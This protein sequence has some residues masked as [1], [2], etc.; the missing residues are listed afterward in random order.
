M[1]FSV[2]M[3][4]SRAVGRVVEH[5]SGAERIVPPDAVPQTVSSLAARAQRHDRG[6]PDSINIR[7]DAI[8]E[9][10]CLRLPALPAR[11]LDCADA[12]AGRRI[13]IDLL[14][15]AGVRNAGA[16]LSLLPAASRL[17]GAMLVDA[18]SL[19]RLEPDR[20]RGIRATCM[21]VSG[22]SPSPVKDHYREAL[23]L[24][25]KVA[26]APHIVAEICISD[27]PGYVIGYVASRKTGY[28]RIARMKESGD[29]CG[30]RIF[31]Y[32]GPHA[33][34]P[35]TVHFIERVPV[36]VEAVPDAPS[37]GG[38]VQS[39]GGGREGRIGDKWAF[40]RQGLE[41][42][43]AAGLARHIVDRASP[44]GAHVEINGRILFHMAS[45]DY[46]GL[47][48][49]PR[50][51]KA[52]ARAV[53][54]YGAGAGASRL[55]S[56]GVE[57]HR[58]LELRLAAFKHAEASLLFNTGYMANTGVITALCGKGD[59]IFSDAL[60]HASII[61]GCRQSRAEVV[62]YRHND[63]QDLEEKARLHAGRKGLIISDAVFSMDGDVAPLPDI[64]RIAD[65]F[66]YISMLDEAHATG[67]LGATGRGIAEHFG[68]SVGP[69]VTVGTLSKALGSEGGFV[70]GRADLIEYLKNRA[71][72]LI[73]STALSPASVAAAMKSL[74]L[75][76]REPELVGR[77][78]GNTAF[79]CAALR[80]EGLA[81]KTESA[82]VPVLVGGEAAACLVSRRLQAE[83]MLLPAI[84]WPSVALGKAR[85]RAAV[86]A[87]H[88]R[89]DLMEVA[90]R[91]AGAIAGR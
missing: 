6:S 79:F 68:L 52:A 27:D 84:R 78:H 17:R 32:D 22:Q 77:L 57:L 61:D 2:K 58:E 18:E 70:C 41:D 87:D 81:V 53:A 69:D 89:A 71:R 42:L 7:V 39:G 60:N 35:E 3:R 9:A 31:L 19:E 74:E 11:A 20:E 14:A 50:V 34:L 8:D 1:L 16:I 40:V 82:I 91:I 49:D 21:D 44:P 63:M 66:G 56:G 86:R 76:C 85:L 67:V 90:R 54:Q 5:V 65:Q 43:R 47:A 64:L 29:P 46:L 13:A 25:T 55:T 12:A 36:L 37:F 23:V 33:A 10:A 26:N 73:F 38:P 45:N 4:A 28:V 80:Q 72:S 88:S 75:L 30:G 48:A 83:G 24:A 15:A 51:R 59:V 62:I